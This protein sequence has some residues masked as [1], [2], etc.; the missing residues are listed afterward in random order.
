MI[1]D[2]PNDDP[3]ILNQNRSGFLFDQKGLAHFF[4]NLD[5]AEDNAEWPEHVGPFYLL[6]SHPSNS[7]STMMGIEISDVQSITFSRI[8]GLEEI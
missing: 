4:D 5:Y 7:I 1:I 8:R 3:M 6:Y 2:L